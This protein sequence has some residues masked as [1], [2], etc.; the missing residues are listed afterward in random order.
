MA[1]A[2]SS[3]AEDKTSELKKLNRSIFIPVVTF[4]KDAK[5]AKKEAEHKARHEAET[6]SRE[7]VMKDYRNTQ[8]LV[9]RGM[10]GGTGGPG[11]ERR[12]WRSGGP[13][14]EATASDDDEEE[15][16]NNLDDIE[17]AVRRLKGIAVDTNTVLDKQNSTLNRITGKVDKVDNQVFTNTAKVRYIRN[18]TPTTPPDSFLHS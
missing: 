9:E 12:A 17:Q 15:L 6:Q 10:V 8:Q 5:R 1:S 2:H 18:E 4:N 16:G 7:E 3:R 11:Q 14:G 13:A